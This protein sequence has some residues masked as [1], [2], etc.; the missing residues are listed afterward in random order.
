M[1]IT[2]DNIK[3]AGIA[4]I[5]L[6]MDINLDINFIKNDISENMLKWLNDN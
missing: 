6:Y 5:S 1:D 2:I 3:N 4:L